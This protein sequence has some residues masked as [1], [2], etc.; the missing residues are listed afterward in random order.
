MVCKHKLVKH[1]GLSP[2]GFALGI[3]FCVWANPLKQYFNRFSDFNQFSD[4]NIFSMNH[5]IMFHF[6]IAMTVA[7]SEGVAAWTLEG[8]YCPTR[9]RKRNVSTKTFLKTKY[10]EELIDSSE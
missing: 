1:F 7:I 5:L 3:V 4:I 2:Q 8:S 10:N 6:N 9:R